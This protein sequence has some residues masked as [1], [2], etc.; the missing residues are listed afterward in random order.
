VIN[1]LQLGPFEILEHKFTA[2]EVKE[3]SLLL[4]GR[5]QIGKEIFFSRVSDYYYVGSMT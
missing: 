4:K 2:Q 3:A 1:V 5:W